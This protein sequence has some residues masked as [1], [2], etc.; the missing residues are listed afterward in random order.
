MSL[1]AKRYIVA[2]LSLLF[3]VALLFVL[4][5]GCDSSGFVAEPTGGCQEVGAQCVLGDG[6][7]GV[8]E[9][10]RCGVGEPPPCFEC[11]S[12]H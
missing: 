1:T 3:L 7:L 4:L 6:P 10:R 8:C 11:T 9:R 12:Q 5:L 2:A